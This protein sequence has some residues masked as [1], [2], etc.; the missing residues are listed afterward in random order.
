MHVWRGVYF[1]G[2]LLS[3][4]T[5]ESAFEQTLIVEVQM[6]LWWSASVEHFQKLFGLTR[7][8]VSQR[9]L[10]LMNIFWYFT[11]LSRD[12]QLA[13]ISIDARSL[14]LKEIRYFGVVKTVLYKSNISCRYWILPLVAFFFYLQI[15]FQNI[16][17]WLFPVWYIAL[18]C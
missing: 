3:S 5:W 12:V 6:C 14:V 15:E 17:F 4:R 9:G 16:F 11:L 10:K 1:E 18:W 2:V 8:K 13:F 7:I